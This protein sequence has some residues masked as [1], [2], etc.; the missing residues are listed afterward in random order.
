MEQL[1]FVTSNEGKIK[2]AE[3]ILGMSIHSFK[4]DLEEIQ[5]LDLEEIIKA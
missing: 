1:Y 3:M 2:E 4:A 5:S